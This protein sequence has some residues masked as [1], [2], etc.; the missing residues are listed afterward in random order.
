MLTGTVSKRR[1][2]AP[3]EVES[4]LE[5]RPSKLGC[6][7]PGAPGRHETLLWL[8]TYPISET[9]SLAEEMGTVNAVMM[10]SAAHHNAVGVAAGWLVKH[11]VGPGR[12][13]YTPEQD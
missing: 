6:W 10:S 8:N 1:F 4:Y 3:E 11:M 2:T 7:R 12:R 9:L 5:I 13:H